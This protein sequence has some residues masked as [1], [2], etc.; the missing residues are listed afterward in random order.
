MEL[1]EVP[2]ITERNVVLKMASM[3]KTAKARLLSDITTARISLAPRNL[4]HRFVVRNKAKA[5]D[6]MDDAALVARKRAPVIGA[7]GLG[8]LLFIA[9]APISKWISKLRNAKTETPGKN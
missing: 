3:R 1:P 6:V 2:R 7:V 9:R 8:I 5:R 4:L